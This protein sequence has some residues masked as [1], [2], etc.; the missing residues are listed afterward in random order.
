M[1]SLAQFLE[2]IEFYVLEAPLAVRPAR[3][4]AADL[5]T[6][7][8]AAVTRAL[9]LP[10]YHVAEANELIARMQPELGGAVVT[11]SS[12]PTSTT[13]AS[14]SPTSRPRSASTRGFSASQ[15]SHRERVEDQGVE[16]VLFAIGSS[17]I[18]LLGALGPDTP[19]GR[20]LVDAEVRVCITSPT[21]WT[22]SRT[23]LRTCGSE[24]ARADRRSAPGGLPQHAR[25]RSC[26][27][28]RWAASWSSSSR[29]P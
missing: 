23:R 8:V 1:P 25:S 3:R 6:L 27:R 14:R 4:T 17:Y 5:R 7:G 26:T 20:F 2:L 28:A 21:A 29:P 16:E 15:P 10:A 9:T 12:S 13:W 19:V 22:T 18:Q 11:L 24:G